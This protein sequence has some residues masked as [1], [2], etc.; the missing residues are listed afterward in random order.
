MPP[1]RTTMA[2]NIADLSRF[3]KHQRTQIVGQAIGFPLLNTAVPLVGVV[4]L[5][6]MQAYRDTHGVTS[7]SSKDWDLVTIFNQFSPPVHLM[8][9]CATSIAMMSCNLVANVVR[10]YVCAYV[11][12]YTCM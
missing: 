12:M 9:A 11:C 3:T 8:A 4:A 2:L 5:G 1:T 6:A 10:V 7:D